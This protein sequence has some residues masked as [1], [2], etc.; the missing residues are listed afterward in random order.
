MVTSCPWAVFSLTPRP[1]PTQLPPFSHC[2]HHS[3]AFPFLPIPTQLL[4]PLLLFLTLGF[5]SERNIDFRSQ[6]SV[7]KLWIWH[8]RSA[9]IMEKVFFLWKK[10]WV[11]RMSKE[12][13]INYDHLR[14]LSDSYYDNILCVNWCF[15]TLDSHIWLSGIPILVCLFVCF[16]SREG[17]SS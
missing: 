9:V 14:G 2:P 4:L 10:Y 1:S 13:F 3:T 6:R 15:C 12:L 11:T 16:L 7:F 17:N 8:F 5:L